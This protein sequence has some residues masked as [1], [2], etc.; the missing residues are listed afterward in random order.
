MLCLMCV[1]IMVDDLGK[2][3]YFENLIDREDPAP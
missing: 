3:F 1:M 2:E